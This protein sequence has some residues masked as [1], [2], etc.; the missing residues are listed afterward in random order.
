MSKI[1]KVLV[2]VF[3]VLLLIGLGSLPILTI[4]GVYL[5]TKLHEMGL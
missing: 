4:Y 5:I 1:F 2:V 3:M